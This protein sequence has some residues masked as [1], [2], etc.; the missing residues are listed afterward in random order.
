ML[1]CVIQTGHVTSLSKHKQNLDDISRLRYEL[2]SSRLS[3]EELQDAITIERQQ[4]LSWMEKHN[5]VIYY[6]KP[7]TSSSFKHKSP[8]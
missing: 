7:F 3:V 1:S 6:L 5:K 2:Q 4:S 8:F